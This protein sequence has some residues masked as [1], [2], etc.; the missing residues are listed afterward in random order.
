MV[1]VHPPAP[2]TPKNQLGP[3]AHP[4]ALGDLRPVGA[5]WAPV[6][7]SIPIWNYTLAMARKPRRPRAGKGRPPDYLARRRTGPATPRIKPRGTLGSLVIRPESQ[8][9]ERLSLPDTKEEIEQFMLDSARRAA[10]AKG[11]NLYEL[12]SDPLRTTEYDLDFSISTDG[13]AEYIELTEL[14]PLEMVGGKYEGLPVS[15]HIGSMADL[16]VKLLMKKVARYAPAVRSRIHLLAYVTD[17]RFRLVKGV[18][19]LVAYWALRGEHGLRSIVYF[20]PEA[21]GGGEIVALHPDD[22]ARYARFDEAL[23][24]GRVALG[25]DLTDPMYGEDGSVGF[26]LHWPPWR[27]S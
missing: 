20:V 15:Y 19:S 10:A 3:S 18:L 16:V 25:T 1:Q 6:S 5:G 27:S 12:T 2:E 24:R 7:A 21:G 11:L 22:P 23:A 4:R 9:F 17:S 26:K 8:Q 13:R 14:A